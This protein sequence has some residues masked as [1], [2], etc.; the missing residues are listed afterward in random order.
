MGD[1]SRPERDMLA[2]RSPCRPNPIGITVAEILSIDGNRIRVTGLNTL[3]GTPILD[4]KYYEEH[5]DSPVG[6]ENES[7]P[8][9]NPMDNAHLIFQ[10]Y[11]RLSIFNRSYR[12]SRLGIKEHESWSL[13]CVVLVF[14]FLSHFYDF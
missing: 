13:S 8:G 1:Q 10:S 4:I 3:N 2:T 9:Y 14:G 7:D 5:F 12:R 11:R 6:I